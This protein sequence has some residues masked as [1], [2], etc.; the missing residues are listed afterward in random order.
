MTYIKY[1]YKF[2]TENCVLLIKFRYTYTQPHWKSNDNN[3]FDKLEFILCM[4]L[5]SRY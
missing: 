3:N 4:F 1:G 5:T 2:N